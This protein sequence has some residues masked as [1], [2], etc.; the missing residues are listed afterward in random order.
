MI[1]DL[2]NR[3]QQNQFLV[4]V[5]TNDYC[6]QWQ[7][8]IGDITGDGCM[9]RELQEYMNLNLTLKS[10][11]YCHQSMAFRKLTEKYA[12]SPGGTCQM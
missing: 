5:R 10:P 7:E 11:I 8:G 9:R 1:V 2:F 6:S 12:N 4:T 3:K